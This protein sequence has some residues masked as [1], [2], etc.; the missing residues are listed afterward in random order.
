MND[1]E[2]QILVLGGAVAALILFY[3][4]IVRPLGKAVEAADARVQS[5]QQSLAELRS[6]N[7]ELAQLRAQLPQGAENLNL[8]S[9]VEGLTRQAELQGK[10]EYIKPG[11]GVQKGTV[12]R[13]SVEVKLARVNLKQLTNLLFQV[14]HGGRFPLR[15]DEIHIK[16]RYDAPDLLDVTLEVFQG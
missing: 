6:L 2:R 10:I 15:V 16:K 3:L 8:M 5:R 7:E 12:K 9:Y 4:L 1:R 13:S 14:E 11:A